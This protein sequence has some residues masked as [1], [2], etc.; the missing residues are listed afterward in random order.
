MTGPLVVDTDTEHQIKIDASSSSGA[1]MHINS[2]GGYAYTVYQNSDRIW[3]LG[4]YGGSSFTIR[5]HTGGTTP[6][7]IDSSGNVGIG[8]STPLSNLHVIGNVG[9]E[10]LNK[11][12]YFVPASATSIGTSVPA[13]HWIGRIDSAG[14]HM[15]TNEGGF[16]GVAGTLGI[17]G[18]GGIAFATSSNTATYASG[19][20]IITAAGNVGIG[21]AN[22]GE[23]LEVNGVLQIKRVGDHPAIRFVEDTTTR[24][25]IGSGD[26]AINGLA[27]AD[28]GISSVGALALGHS[29]GVE[30]MR[31]HTNGN[32]GIGAP[33]PTEKLEVDGGIKISNGNSRLYFGTEGGTSYRALEGS[34]NGSLL[35]VGENYTDIA[36]QGN[37]GIGLTS[38]AYSLDLGGAMRIAASR[39]TFV[40][41]SEDATAAAHIFCK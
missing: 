17:A 28:F 8:E 33:A 32:V 41:A 11:L 3:R 4:A 15:T 27:A 13:Q 39:S 22:P 1:S 9:V 38:P 18:K 35:Q 24:G 26:W 2:A 12:Q 14:Y 5:D 31:I 7:V 23:K 16:A 30:R 34:T 6:L 37:V 25:Y 20:M 21:T 10:G 29:G 19:R 36:L 40:D